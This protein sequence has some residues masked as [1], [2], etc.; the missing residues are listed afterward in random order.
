MQSATNLNRV[1]NL[2]GCTT[3]HGE[4]SYHARHI[5]DDEFLKPWKNNLAVLLFKEV[6]RFPNSG[7]H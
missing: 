2:S 3:L 7:H 4:L 6:I 5:V 1:I